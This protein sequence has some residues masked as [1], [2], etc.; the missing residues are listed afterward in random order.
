[1]SQGTA[2]TVS[3]HARR[4]LGT[5]AFRHPQHRHGLPVRGNDPR[6][7]DAWAVRMREHLQPPR[8]V[9]TRKGAGVANTPAAAGGSTPCSRSSVRASRVHTLGLKALPRL[10]DQVSKAVSTT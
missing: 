7:Q 1:M 10:L 4:W 6:L 9:Q 8:I 3:R 5:A 2:P